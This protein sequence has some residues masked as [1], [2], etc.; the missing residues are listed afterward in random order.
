MSWFKN[1]WQLVKDGYAAGVKKYEDKENA[2]RDRERRQG[3]KQ[4]TQ[5]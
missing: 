2:K 5:K 3:T 1:F 4:D